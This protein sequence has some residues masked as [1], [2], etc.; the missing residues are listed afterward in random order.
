MYIVQPGRDVTNIVPVFANNRSWEM[1]HAP[2]V[3]FLAIFLAVSMPEMS[4]RV[5]D[6]P[7]GTV[8]YVSIFD[9]KSG[10]CIYLTVP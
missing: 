3:C 7:C 4:A 1:S 8:G 6:R 9:G 2:R 10:S 5:L